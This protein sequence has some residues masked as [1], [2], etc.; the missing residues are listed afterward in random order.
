MK[1]KISI[2]DQ[3]LDGKRTIYFDDQHSLN[4]NES[5][6][7]KTLHTARLNF[8]KEN[9]KSGLELGEDLY[10]LLNGCGGKLDH[11]LEQARLKGNPLALYLKIP[12]DLEALPFELLS[13]N[14]QFLAQM[15]FPSVHIVRA[16]TD[17]GSLKEPAVDERPLKVLFMACSPIDLKSREVLSFEEEE[18]LILSSV[19]K[20]AVDLTIE[21]SGSLSG[22]FEILFHKGP[23][24]VVHIIG[25]AGHDDR[26]GVVFY[27]EDETGRRD[28]VTADRLWN[29]ALK[30]NQPQLL[31]LSGCST[32]KDGNATVA[33]SFAHEMVAK[34]LSRALGWGLPVSDIGATRLTTELY[35]GLGMGKSVAEAVD[36][37]SKALRDSYHPWPLLRV[38]TDD[39]PL[40]SLIAPGQLRHY[41]ERERTYKTLKDNRVR[42]LEK[43]FVGRRR[44]I[45]QG[46]RILK[47]I[48][49]DQGTRR[50]GV[51]IRGAAG[52]GKSCLAGK[53][54]E[55][56]KDLELVVV[57]G[58]LS[59]PDIVNQLR[60]LFDK[61]GMQSGIELLKADL[62]YEDRIKALFRSTFLKLPVMIYLDDFEQNLIKIGDCWELEDDIKPVLRPILQALDWNAESRTRVIITSRHPFE[63]EYEGENLSGKLAD[64]TLSAFRDADL[65]KKTAELSHIAKSPN[66]PL[67]LE[68]SGGN[69]RL[70]EWLE[71]VAKDEGKYDLNTLKKELEGKSEEFIREYL[72]DILAGTGGEPFE[73]FMC[74]AA[75]FRRPVESEA[76]ENFG[77]PSFLEKGVDLTLFEKEQVPGQKPIYWVMPVIRHR[78]WDKLSEESQ[79]KLHHEALSWYEKKISDQDKPDYDLLQEAVYHALACGKIYSA[80]K[81][82]IF[83]GSYQKAMLL[84]R[85]KLMLQ[86]AVADK[87]THRVVDEAKKGEKEIVAILLN[88]LGVAYLDLGDAQKSIKSFNQALSIYQ[89]VFGDIHQC[90][91][92]SYN[93]LGKAY[94][95]LGEAQK[96]IEFD[97]QALSIR[98]KVFSDRHP[99]VAES[100]N[101]L[102]LAFSV[103][104]QAQKA[105]GLYEKALSIYQA[106][107]SDKHPTVATSYN[108]LGL[109]YR[110]MGEAK[111]AIG[112]YEKALSIYQALYSDKHPIVATSYNYLGL[113]FRDLGEAQKAIGYHKQALSIRQAVFGDNHPHVAASYN[114]L[115]GAYR[116]LGGAQKAIGYYEKALS[117]VQT[118]FGGN[119]QLVAAS[120]N[121]LGAVYL[122]LGEA[123]KAIGY[124]E[125]ALSIRIVIYGNHHP[126][127]AASYNNI[128]EAYRN[129][130]ETQ[131]A[132]GFHEKAL[133]IV[134]AVFGDNHPHVAASYNNLGKGYCNLGDAKKAIVF[135]EKAVSIYLALYSDSHPCVGMSY[136]NLGNAYNALGDVQMAIGYFNKALLIYQEVYGDN[137][138]C[139]A[140]IYDN[141]GKV[142]RDLGEAQKATGFYKQ[143][144]RIFRT[145]FGDE[146]PSTQRILENIKDLMKS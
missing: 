76:F 128:G 119:H 69:P 39:T 36:S 112:L 56:F 93:N 88:S 110:K 42:V 132:I 94:R 34:G 145:V 14:G 99:A 101:S 28:P 106:L 46:V 83:L 89:A 85:D 86:Q 137:H 62:D 127:V 40:F 91:A 114:N 1:A 131:K 20:F 80:C 70:L 18:E 138:P 54:V 126:D 141:L 78:Q 123:P 8:W 31:F 38:F 57:H 26:L 64:L 129:L 71:A 11:L 22:L 9:E 5:E 72:V 95:I 3:T 122:D 144:L 140:T 117:I 63:F 108:Y 133:S 116:E 107:Y 12:C 103:L 37:A 77:D 19:E 45:Q 143:A 29:E 135:H 79:K 24:D 58:K 25:Y 41:Q 120:Y 139:V 92:T 16:V 73:E 49:D 113:A 134:K 124:F 33:E 81:L 115:G 68:I 125:R 142:Y 118:V 84:Y 100:Y 65:N 96:A 67:Y 121:N 43:G 35:R 90:I 10:K 2:N 21:D 97:K 66:R 48:S 53:L 59:R 75:V 87:I 61:R 7:E 13:R 136:I 146:H 44:E 50:F 102:G 60:R 4:I 105:I 55:R 74:Q 17:R 47:G 104:G 15:E 109:E 6:L 111:K 52:V 130:G 51:F 23:F 32:G 30:D 27:M 82:A 98:K